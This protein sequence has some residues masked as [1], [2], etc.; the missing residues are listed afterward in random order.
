MFCS[1]MLIPFCTYNYRNIKDKS[2]TKRFYKYN[3]DADIYIL[4]YNA[5]LIKFIPYLE[6]RRYIGSVKPGNPIEDGR[7]QPERVNRTIRGF[8][9]HDMKRSPL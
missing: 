9:N 1:K 5:N 3:I 8:P 7:C 2:Q 4:Y 6:W